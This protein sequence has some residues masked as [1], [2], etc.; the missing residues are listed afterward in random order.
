MFTGT[1]NVVFGA[2]LQTA[3]TAKNT[4]GI[5]NRK[6]QPPKAVMIHRSI[7]TVQEVLGKTFAI[8][9]PKFQSNEALS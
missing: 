9:S 1:L 3:G 7:C 2:H 6:Q 8:R 5:W 4:A